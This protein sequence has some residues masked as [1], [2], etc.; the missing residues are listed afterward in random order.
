[1]QEV[2]K[3]SGIITLTTDFGDAD[4]FVAQMKGVIFSINRDAN[5]V[6]ITHKVRPFSIQE[7]SHAISSA[8]R[9]FP[10]G[11]IH[12]VVT[13]PGV[14]SSRRGLLLL[15]GGHYFIGPDNGIFT[16]VAL[17]SGQ[18]RAFCLCEE[19]LLL[20]SPGRTFQGRDL[21]A[22]VAA[23]LSKGRDISTFGQK[24]ED[25]LMLQAN[26]PIEGN[27]SITGVV[28]HIDNFGNAVTNIPCNEITGRSFKVFFKEWRL[29]F[30]SFYKQAEGRGLSCLC[31][32]QGLLEVFVYKASASQIHGINIGDSIKIVMQSDG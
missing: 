21:F 10:E 7:A 9:Y 24:I 16:H 20:P 31:N 15:K 17:E 13:D 12:I 1:M 25:I 22:P 6:D 2:V 18:Y 26:L 28:I 11:T 27:S 8:Y 32:S 29:D 3:P 19:G 5:I 4:T 23:M 14:G 30:F